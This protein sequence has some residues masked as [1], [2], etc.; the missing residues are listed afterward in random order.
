MIARL[1]FAAKVLLWA[2]GLSACTVSLPEVDPTRFAC[3][4]DRRLDEGLF[5]CPETHACVEQSCQPRLDCQRPELDALGCA[6]D[7]D[8]CELVV[9]DQVA[10]VACMRGLQF[11][12]STRPP[13]LL[14]DC[15]CPDGTYCTGVASRGTT[16]GPVEGPLGPSLFVFTEHSGPSLP[17]GVLDIERELEAARV[18]A[19]ACGSEADCPAGH[20]CRPAV[21]LQAHLLEV[22]LSAR[23]TVGVCMPDVL[24]TSSTATSQLDPEACYGPSAC[25]AALGR[26]EGIC[27]ANPMAVPDHPVLPIGDAA[28]GVRRALRTHC[29]PRPSTSFKDP[30]LGCLEHEECT[31]QVCFDGRC[32]LLCDPAEAGSC[33]G[34]GRLCRDRL[35]RRTLPAEGPTLED[36]VFLCDR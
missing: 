4:D 27:Q 30:G 36:R 7:L 6:P 13:G 31:T 28:W 18:C 32:A 12:T 10:R 15:A 3:E 14:D 2:V 21:V 5:P 25:R 11:E 35:I 23:S 34:T 1:R 9:G 16:P 20:T 29:V 24:R 33:G 26:T 17:A 8:R 22:E 19:R